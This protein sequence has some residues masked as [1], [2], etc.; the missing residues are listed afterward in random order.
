MPTIKRQDLPQL[1][2]KIAAG[3]IAPVYLLVGERFLCREAAAALEHA[4]L[5]DEQQR[6][7]QLTVID[8]EREEPGKTLARLRT[9]SLFGGRQLT[10]VV[11]T[12]LFYSKTMAKTLWEKAEAARAGQD[13][14]ETSRRLKAMLS[15]AGLPPAA[16][17]RDQLT[18][19]SASQWQ[20]LFGFAKP[21]EIAWAGD[22]LDANDDLAPAPGKGEAGEELQAA[23]EGGLPPN[24]I[25]L[26]LA[27][28]ADKRK[29]LYKYLEKHAVII[30]LGVDTGGNAAARKEQATL[31][32]NLV[33]EKLAPFDK[34]MRPDAL[35]LL[36]ERVGFH[37]VAVV[38]ETEK[39]ALYADDRNTISRREVEEMVGRTREEAIFEL[40]EAFT[41]GDLAQSVIVLGRLQQGGM[42]ALAILGGLRNHVRKLLLARAVQDQAGRP[43]NPG[44]AYPAFQKSYLPQVKAA[45]E[46]QAEQHP[47]PEAF[48]WPPAF[49]GHPYA[50]YQLFLQA[51]KLSARQLRALLRALLE[52]EHRLKGS[53]LPENAVLSAL[54][55]ASRQPT[56]AR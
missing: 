28:T 22:Y 36:L 6:P 46:S 26:L 17:H 25:L 35:E 18:D 42:H 5:P 34:K 54:L 48:A 45:W 52:A 55:F 53:G 31:L 24:K 40:S 1:L 2:E 9:Y 29:K 8:G 33:L 23:L 51:G 10:K 14:K 13:A 21:A 41:N 3:E 7:N 32:K 15:L 43:C 50:L 19:L 49:P 12:R 56:A 37:P 39:L 20:K 4:L 44:L 47:T 27:E 30:D 38:M 11:D 16:W